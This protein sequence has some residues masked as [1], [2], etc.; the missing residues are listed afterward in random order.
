MPLLTDLG[1]CLLPEPTLFN[2]YP[3]Y[4]YSHKN[5]NSNNGS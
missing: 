4:L 5:Y 2:F 3:F 1:E